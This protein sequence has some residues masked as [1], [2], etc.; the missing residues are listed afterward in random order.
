MA[1]HV[2]RDRAGHPASVQAASS[3]ARHKVRR[4]S[5]TGAGIR[6]ADSIVHQPDRLSPQ[7]FAASAADKSSGA[8]APSTWGGGL[9]GMARLPVPKGFDD[10]VGVKHKAATR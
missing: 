6:P 2:Q 10:G 4:P 1:P 8:G 7:S 9:A 3:P 5:L